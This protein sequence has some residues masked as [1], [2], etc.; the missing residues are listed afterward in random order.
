MSK[1]MSKQTK[2][3]CFISFKKI[4]KKEQ[5]NKQEQTNE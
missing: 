1:F 3:Y 4:Q 5:I 2:S